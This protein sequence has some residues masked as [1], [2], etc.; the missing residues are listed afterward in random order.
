MPRRFRRLLA[1]GTEVMVRDEHGQT[2]LHLA[3]R[4]GQAG[5]VRHLIAAG[6]P[7]DARDA[8]GN[9]PL[10]RA[11][12]S[13]RREAAQVLIA[14]GADVNAATRFGHTPLHLAAGTK[15]ED[16]AELLVAY[17]ADV[18]APIAGGRRS[19]PLH[20][21]AEAGLPKLAALLIR[22]G[23]DLHAQNADGRTALDLAEGTD[24]VCRPGRSTRD[25]RRSPRS[26][27]GAAHPAAG[28]MRPA[29]VPPALDAS[30]SDGPARKTDG[31]A[32][33][34]TRATGDGAGPRGE[35]PGVFRW[36]SRRASGMCVD[37][38]QV[39]LTSR[40]NPPARRRCGPWATAARWPPGR[41]SSQRCAACPRPSAWAASAWPPGSAWAAGSV[42]ISCRTRR[43]WPV[44]SGSAGPMPSGT[45][46]TPRSASLEQEMA[47]RDGA[48]PQAQAETPQEPT[49][50][51]V[52]LIE[53]QRE[54]EAGAG[55]G[56]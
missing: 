12:G 45:A 32:G 4:T 19:R 3:A 13:G 34:S 28:N 42:P 22:R 47:A 43:S 38:C 2:A 52:A 23:A 55:R 41:C 29:K 36:T 1:A 48:R 16:L 30:A 14:A 5:F 35:P 17:G 8:D 27:A 15:R 10:H 49:H 33:V 53:R 50:L 51:F 18:D 21:A 25:I 26:Y 46:R 7:V 20:L 44:P 40:R 54:N 11:V 9:T 56:V 6:A 37:P 39:G 24:P 31:Q